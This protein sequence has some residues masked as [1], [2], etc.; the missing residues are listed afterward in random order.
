MLLASFSL[1]VGCPGRVSSGGDDRPDVGGSCGSAPA[2]AGVEQLQELIAY[3]STE[4]F[5]RCFRREILQ[6]ASHDR[7]RPVQCDVELVAF[8]FASCFAQPPSSFASL[9]LQVLRSWL[10]FFCPEV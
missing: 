7:F 6:K 9:W 3:H 1:I 10:L 5:R 4:E 2:D 8:T